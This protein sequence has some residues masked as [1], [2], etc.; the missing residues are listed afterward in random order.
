M[1]KDQKQIND[2][3]KKCDVLG[4]KLQARLLEIEVLKERVRELEACEGF[5]L[6]VI[7]EQLDKMRSE[8]LEEVLQIVMDCYKVNDP[9]DAFYQVECKIRSLKEKK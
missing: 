5:K 3:K 7:K 1:T 8:A 9:T 2:L 4:L 6:E